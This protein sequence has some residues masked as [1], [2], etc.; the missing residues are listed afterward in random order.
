MPGVDA[1]AIANLAAEALVRA[2]DPAQV[3]Q[4]R[5][6]LR[7][8]E[9]PL[10]NL[11]TAG[12]PSA[13]SALAVPERERLLL[14]WA[15]SPIALKRSAF[16][17]LRKLLSFLAYAAPDATGSVGPPGT[18]PTIHRSVRPGHRAGPPRSIARRVPS[19]SCWRQTSSS[20]DPAPAAA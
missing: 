6:V 1:A 19:R 20:S 12:R 7:S 8:L 9:Q 4:L 13:L 18:R 11:V 16:Q 14:R 2:A 10:F 15:R 17:A 5:L 3:T